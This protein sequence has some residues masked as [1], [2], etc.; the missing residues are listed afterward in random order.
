MLSASRTALLVGLLSSPGSLAEEVRAV[1]DPPV[2]GKPSPIDI[3]RESEPR[4]RLAAGARLRQSPDPAA[5]VVEILA[6]PVELPVLE[7]R[8]RWVKVRHAAWQAWVAPSGVES[9]TG[10]QPGLSYAPDEARLRRARAL[11]ARDSQASSLGPFTLFTDVEDPQL[12]TNLESVAN[13]IIPAYVSRY[14][15][16]PG[17]RGTDTLVLLAREEDYR[18]FESSEPSIANSQTSGYTTIGLCILFAGSRSADDIART[19]IHELTHL[20]NRRALGIDTPAWLEEGMAQDLAFSRLNRAG[21]I[22]L[23][24]LGGTVT[25]DITDLGAGAS[26]TT[27]AYSGPR[28]ALDHLI[29]NW[30]DPGRPPLE[31]LVELP[32][33]EF[34]RPENRSLLY[35]ESAFLIRYLLDGAKQRLGP[36][37]NSYLHAVAAEPDLAKI[38]LWSHLGHQPAKIESELYPWLRSQAIANGLRLP[39]GR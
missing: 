22:E 37:F 16:D 35:A 12:L 8:G 5:P 3:G 29:L 2:L 13:S 32:K 39:R 21:G 26:Q 36:G 14:G 9:T 17:I 10:S 33:S 27:I 28:A 30:T 24:S 31:V 19:L 15:I 1:Q 7:R 4:I 38:S 23:G 6:A 34:L 18:E 20:L 11:L 25:R